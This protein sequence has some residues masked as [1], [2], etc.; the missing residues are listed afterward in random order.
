MQY[1]SPFTP[2]YTHAGPPWFIHTSANLRLRT[3]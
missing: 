3:P 2:N 1:K